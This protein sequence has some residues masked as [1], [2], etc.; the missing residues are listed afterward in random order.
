M[1]LLLISGGADVAHAQY[2]TKGKKEFSGIDRWAF[3]TN[4]VDWALTIPN[5]SVEYD[6]SGADNNKMTLGLT[7]RYNWNTKQVPM[8]YYVFDLFQLRPEYRYYWR[9]TKAQKSEDNGGRRRSFREWMNDN[10]FTTARKNPKEGRI[11]YI[12]AYADAGLYSI[13]AGEYGHKG[14]IY[15][16]GFSMGYAV[17]KY[18]YKTGNI[19][20]ELGFALGLALMTDRVYTLDSAGDSYRQVSSESRGLHVAPFPIVSSLNLSLAWRSKSI[21]EKYNFTNADRLRKQ[22]KEQKLENRLEEREQAKAEAERLKAE[23]RKQKEAKAAAQKEKK[24]NHADKE[25]N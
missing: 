10:I 2:R 11:N 15:T 23:K 16:I 17:P 22:E 13:K 4:V 18:Q 19:D 9:P 1:L 6:L 25:R 24:S 21:K 14:Q 3:K 20:V 12:G 7:A 5:L 8:P